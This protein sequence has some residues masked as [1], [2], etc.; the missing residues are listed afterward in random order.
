LPKL[1]VGDGVALYSA[2][3]PER[4]AN[5][6]A[7][8]MTQTREV[9]GA[10]VLNSAFETLEI[11]IGG[12]TVNEEERKVEEQRVWDDFFCTLVGWGEHPGYYRE[13]ATKPTVGE[14]ADKADEMM[15]VRNERINRREQRNEQ[16]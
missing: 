15:R 9:M 6:L 11:E 10:N 14:C 3:H 2:S 8:S 16:G 13:N 5:A 1:L 12:S 7:R 4:M